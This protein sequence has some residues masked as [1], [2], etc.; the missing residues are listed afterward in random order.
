LGPSHI[1]VKDNQNDYGATPS[2]VGGQVFWESPDIFLVPRDA[3]VDVAAV[4]SETLITPGGLFDIWVRVHNDLG[5][6]DVNDARALIY[7][8]KPSALSTEWDPITNEMYVGDNSSMTGVK[9]LAGK[10]ALIGPIHFTAPMTGI[11]DG[12][13]CILAAIMADGE[14][15]VDDATVFR[16][17]DSNQVAQRNI[18]F[19]SC[20]YPLTNATTSNGSLILTLSV[21]TTET[22][23]SLTGL[24]DIEVVFDDAD[25]SWFRDWMSQAIDEG[26]FTVTHDDGAG[27][28]TVR[29]G[30]YSVVLDSVELDAG[31]SRTAAGIFKLVPGASVSLQIAGNLTD[32]N[33]ESTV[34]AENGGTCQFTAPAAPPPP[35]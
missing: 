23:P 2:N 3:H 16:A 12:H 17:P 24:P 27:T 30:A 19:T 4:S 13:R 15:A 35:K 26:T 7:L 10:E 25:S 20:A 18:Q 22:E 31:E 9:V 11:G 33:D 5:C 6:S 14:H 34:L 21:P 8:A 29:L 1:Y 32:D 28:T